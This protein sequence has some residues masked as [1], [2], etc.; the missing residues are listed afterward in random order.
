MTQQ[1]TANEQSKSMKVSPLSCCRA[2]RWCCCMRTSYN[3]IVFFVLLHI[4]YVF[5]KIFSIIL[6]ESVTFFELSRQFTTL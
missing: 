1:I 4:F 5:R 2:C 3:G 6:A